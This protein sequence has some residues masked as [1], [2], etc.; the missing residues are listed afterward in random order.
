LFKP[1]NGHISHTPGIYKLSKQLVCLFTLPWSH[2]IYL[3]LSILF[4]TVNGNKICW[5]KLSFPCPW[6]KLH[7]NYINRTHNNSRFTLWSSMV[8]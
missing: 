2:C 3:H 7:N 6:Y 5:S 4:L 1:L 8:Y